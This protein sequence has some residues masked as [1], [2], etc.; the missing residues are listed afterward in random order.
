MGEQW[1][2]NRLGG[3]KGVSGGRDRGE[4]Y[5]GAFRGVTTNA[6]STSFLK[7]RSSEL[8]PR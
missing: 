7:D 5:L 2:N 3:Y 6:L 1:L 4:E 8:G